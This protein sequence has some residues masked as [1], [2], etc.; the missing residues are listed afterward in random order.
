MQNPDQRWNGQGRAPY[1]ILVLPYLKLSNGILYAIFKRADA[2]YWQFIA[3]GGEGAELPIEAARREAWEEAG[4]PRETEL[5]ML[6]SRNTVPVLELAGRLLWG[7]QALVVPEFCF[8][9]GLTNRDLKISAE[10]TEYQWADY[11][12]CRSM[13]RWD[14]NRNALLELNHRLRNKVAP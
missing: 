14:S 10:H 2:S 9:V 13:L 6:Q 12:T 1:Q 5:F 4:I 8:G 7:P 3:G 11:E